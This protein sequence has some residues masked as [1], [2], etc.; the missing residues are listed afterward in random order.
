M[1]AK[2]P[3]G[4]LRVFTDAIE[5]GLPLVFD[6]LIIIKVETVVIQMRNVDVAKTT[7]ISRKK[8]FI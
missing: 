4:S 2:L 7:G 5:D 3:L 6:L 8:L 1:R